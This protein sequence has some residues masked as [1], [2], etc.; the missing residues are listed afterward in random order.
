MKRRQLVL[1]AVLMMVAPWAYAQT[2]LTEQSHGLLPG[3]NNNM[4]LTEHNNPGSAGA[5]QV[6]DYSDLK[7]M[8]PFVGQ[9]IDPAVANTPVQFMTSN[10]VLNEGSLFAFL[11]TNPDRLLVQGLRT[12]NPNAPLIRSYYEPVVKMKY[13][14]SFGD[15]HESYTE[16]VET[17]AN[18]TSVPFSYEY[19]IVADGEGT[20]L[21]PGTSLKNALRVLTTQT[22]NYQ[23]PN[24]SYGYGYTILTYRWYVQSH[25]FPVLVLIYSQDRDGKL[26]FLQGAYNPVVQPADETVELPIA[27]DARVKD[28]PAVASASVADFN[29][30]PN[31]FSTQLNIAYTLDNAAN[32]RITLYNVNGQLVRTLYHGQDEAGAYARNF[33]GA[34]SSL[35]E[36][37]YI[38][39]VGANGQTISRMVYH[40]K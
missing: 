5:G 10:A 33:S 7:D 32:V 18:A 24:Y 31:P 25:R 20:L 39:I 22:I 21:L 8:G 40:V 13:P 4:R 15:R 23:H 34:V 2:V 12:G 36:G 3:F 26:H 16:G 30:Y 27:A 14:F 37:Q 35:P 19:D 29:V 6:W 28:L 38:V 17:A 11:D 9:N 1:L